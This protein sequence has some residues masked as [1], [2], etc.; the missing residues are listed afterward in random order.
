MAGEYQFFHRLGLS[1][2]LFQH[3][4]V[5]DGVLA[6]DVGI[7]GIHRDSLFHGKLTAHTR[8]QSRAR[9]LVVND[10]VV[11][12]L[13]TIFSYDKPSANAVLRRKDFL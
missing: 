7:H 5:R 9:H 12:G 2:G 11:T 3:S 4:S 10:Q 1:D 8:A 6:L 13:V